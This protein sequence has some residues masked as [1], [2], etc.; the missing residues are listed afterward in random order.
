MKTI[1]EKCEQ[2]ECPRC[3]ERYEERLE[4]IRNL[5]KSSI[6]VLIL[7][8]VV[9][10]SYHSGKFLGQN[11]IVYEYYREKYSNEDQEAMTKKI[12]QQEED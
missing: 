12:Q 7:Y 3:C 6:N 11:E 4:W 2:E 9:K 5:V 1:C 8:G 10:I